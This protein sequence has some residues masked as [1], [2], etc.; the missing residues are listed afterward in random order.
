[1]NPTETPDEHLWPGQHKITVGAPPGRED[2]EGVAA[3]VDFWH[4][5]SLRTLVRLELDAQDHEEIRDGGVLWLSFLGSPIRPFMAQVS[6]IPPPPH[7]P[8]VLE[9]EMPQFTMEAVN[10]LMTNIE[11]RALTKLATDLQTIGIEKGLAPDLVEKM[12]TEG[13]TATLSLIAVR[14]G[15]AAALDVVRSAKGQKFRSA[16][17]LIVPG[18]D[19]DPRG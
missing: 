6:K 11:D 5:G 17:R 10:D 12:L 8:A 9:G 18:Q 13:A 14:A 3:V 2:I 4:D 16:P 19:D 7:R 1:M 15:A